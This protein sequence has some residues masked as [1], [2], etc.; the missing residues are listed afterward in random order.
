M[1]FSI[2]YTENAKKDLGKLDKNTARRVKAKLAAASENPVPFVKRLQ[3]VE[4]YSLRVG[5]YRVLMSIEWA[6]KRFIISRIGH[7]KNV[8]EKPS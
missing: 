3:G 8:Y 1:P 7:R 6:S 2:F 4:L 5:N